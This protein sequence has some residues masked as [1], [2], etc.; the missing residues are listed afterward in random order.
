[1][2][3]QART[4]GSRAFAGIPTHDPTRGDRVYAQA[5]TPG[6]SAVTEIPGVLS[7]GNLFVL[8]LLQL[9]RLDMRDG[10]VLF[11]AVLSGVVSKG[12]CLRVAGRAV[13]QVTEA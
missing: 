2:Y 5:S 4:Q 12:A 9:S 10:Q 8:L 7:A 1:M 11:P 3:A 13:S 6:S